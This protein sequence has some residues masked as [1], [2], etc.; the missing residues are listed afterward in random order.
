M[1]TQKKTTVCNHLLQP[2]EVILKLSVHK[3]VP[4]LRRDVEP[5]T[6]VVSHIAHKCKCLI[7]LEK[8]EEELQSFSYLLGRAPFPVFL[9]HFIYLDL[10]QLS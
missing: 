10:E 7:C 8:K 3:E 9:Y 6:C 2:H 4:E 1:L 5:N